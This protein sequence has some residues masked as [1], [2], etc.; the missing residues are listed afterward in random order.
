MAKARGTTTRRPSSGTAKKTPRRLEPY[1]EKRDF[2]ATP[3]PLPKDEDGAEAPDKS[4]HPDPRAVKKSAPPRSAAAAPTFVVQ[5]HDARRLHY[6][7]RLEHEGVLLSWAVPKGPSYDPKVKRLAVHVED[8]PLDYAAFEG[9][10]P[11]GQYGA[12]EVEVWDRGTF[13]LGTRDF[14]MAAMLAKGHVHV[15]L[16]GE[17]LRGGWHLV[18][19]RDAKTWLFFKADDAYANAH[20]DVLASAP[21]TVGPAPTA[22]EAAS[23]PGDARALIKSLG[24]VA[25]AVSSRL[26]GPPSEYLFEIKYD[27]YRILGGKVGTNV[28]LVSR[29]GLDWTERFPEIARAV[30]RLPVRELVIDG[31]A[32]VIDDRGRPSFEALQRHLSG[33]RDVGRLAFP[34]FDLLWLDGRDLRSLPVEE[35]RQK[36]ES[37]VRGADAPITFSTAIQGELHAVLEAA[38][39][40]GLEGLVAKRRGSAYVGG[41][42]T[43]WIKMKFELRQDCVV[44]GYTPMSGTHVAG[45]LVLGLHD[46]KGRFVYAG[47]VGTGLTDA[48]RAD[49]AKRLDRARASDCPFEIDPRIP[50]VRW[51]KPEIC[52]EIGLREW[53]RDGSPRFP[54]FLG[55]RED[56]A[57]RECV[58][59]STE[60]FVDMS[61]APRGTRR[62]HEGERTGGDVVTTDAA[63]ERPRP[64]TVVPL[65][66]ADKVLF[67]KDGLTKR[68]VFR[69]YTDIA[70]VMLPHLRGRPINMQRWPDGIHAEE[71]FQHNAP[72]RAP[73]YVRQVP[74]DRDEAS[75]V[76]K[77]ARQKWRVIVENV[78]TLQYLANLAALTLHQRHAHIPPTATT[79][80]AIAR[81][82]ATPDYVVIDLDP[83]DGPFSDLIDVALA[84]RK[85][86]DLLELESCV[87]T[88]GKRGLHVL[89]PLAPGFTHD[90]AIA[91]SS[92]VAR[93]VAKVLPDIATTE[94][95]KDRR[96]GRLYVDVAQNG[97]GRT[98]VAPYSLR[99]EDGAPV[100]TPL[101]WSEVT[102]A[103]DPSAFNLR[104]ILAR[105]D[106]RG[107]LLAPL[108]RGRGILPRTGGRRPEGDHSE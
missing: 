73:P 80:E 4:S 81:A 75:A 88:S 57:P 101:D 16:H 15:V 27:G 39:T 29:N 67:P 21:G 41:P 84:V 98:I 107:D 86:L 34:T 91:F 20:F 85:L 48:L 44:C 72:P 53:T 61:R 3:E 68:D 87:K 28:R 70:P 5:K 56:K 25:R 54:R 102:E 52:I 46:A 77:N 8:H 78:E 82:L 104:T 58:R 47:R 59:E 66:N 92:E 43:S 65:T 96:R 83:G 105:V 2:T 7:L 63:A 42:T 103:L 108:L 24:D 76:V 51:A 17:K 71:W 22:G 50:D 31:E 93:A 90:D 38:R 94:M 64:T 100:S 18:R 26:L 30:G 60:S 19:T 62:S 36:L 9:H 6:D 11:K 1:A 40:A 95:R 55:F 89:V 13:E 74:F 35:R 33:E 97:R 79:E 49:F 99:A 106:A 14:D 45:A 12:G 37:L 32:C 69:Y 10:I 23:G